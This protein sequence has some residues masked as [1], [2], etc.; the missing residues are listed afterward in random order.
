[1]TICR[2][3]F[4]LKTLSIKRYSD[5]ISPPNNYFLFHSLVYNYFS[6]CSNCSPH[7]SAYLSCLN[8]SPTCFSTQHKKTRKGLLY[9]RFFAL[10]GSIQVQ[11]Q[12]V[13]PLLVNSYLKEN[14]LNF[15][16]GLAIFL[17]NKL[18]IFL[19]PEVC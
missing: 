12:R 7:I 5:D 14:F 11:L 19:K 3:G 17:C 2:S 9:M 6:I 16:H 10:T 18:C 1:M 13:C 4:R 8:T 15:Y